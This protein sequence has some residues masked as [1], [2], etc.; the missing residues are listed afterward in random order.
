MNGSTPG[1]AAIQ[2]YFVDVDLKAS[3]PM[4]EY[5]IEASLASLARSSAT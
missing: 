5:F 3:R 1:V 2:T 4:E